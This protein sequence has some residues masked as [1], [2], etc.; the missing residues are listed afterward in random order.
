VLSATTKTGMFAGRIAA[1]K[2]QKSTQLVYRHVLFGSF[3]L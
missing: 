1:V 3:W 2:L